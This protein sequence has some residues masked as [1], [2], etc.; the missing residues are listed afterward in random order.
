[1]S[2]RNSNQDL[3][4]LAGGLN[5]NIPGKK[6]AET[7][8]PFIWTLLVVIFD[9]KKFENFRQKNLEIFSTKDS[10]RKWWRKNEGKIS[11]IEQ[12]LR[13]TMDS[14]SNSKRFCRRAFALRSRG[15]QVIREIR[16]REKFAN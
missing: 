5:E 16:N 4:G 12:S 8:S 6:D 14:P 1:M 13:C 2:I 10:A 3:L 7:K 15:C 11:S 9:K